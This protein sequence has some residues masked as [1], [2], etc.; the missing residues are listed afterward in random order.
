LVGNQRRSVHLPFYGYLFAYFWSGMRPSEVSGLKW[1]HVDLAHETARVRHRYRGRLYGKKLKTKNAKRTVELHPTLCAILRQMRPAKLHP[2]GFVF[3]NLRG[4][5]IRPG[6]FSELWYDALRVLDPPIRPRGLY[7]TKH[8]LCSL[9]VSS[10]DLNKLLWLEKQTGEPW[11]TLRRHYATF[12]PTP[13][14]ERTTF[15]DLDPSLAKVA[16]G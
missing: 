4:E 5:P 12:F 3:T 7:Q 11:E 1:S 15:R 16:K 13:P 14:E 10:G 8:T 9:T 6:A 2:H